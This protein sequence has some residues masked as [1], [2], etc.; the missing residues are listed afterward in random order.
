MPKRVIIDTDPGVDDALALILALRSPELEIEAITTVSGNVPVEQAT[1]NVLRVLNLLDPKPRPPVAKG[2]AGPFKKPLV[3]ATVVHGAD[4]LGDLDRFKNLDGSPRYLE[5]EVPRDLPSA[6]EAILELLGRYPGELTLITLGPLTNLAQALL[7]DR[8]RVKTLREVVIMGGA[9]RAPG[10]ATPAAEF[11]ISIDPHAAQLVFA[12]GLPITLVPLDVTEKV[13]L[14]RDTIETIAQSSNDPLSQF[15][16]DATGKVIEFM[17]RVAEVPA[18]TLHDPLAVG[19][20]IDPSFVKTS[21]L[22]VD[23]ETDGRITEGM[24]VADLRSI[25]DDLKQPPN[26]HGALEVDADRFL[27]FFL[28]RICRRDVTLSVSEGSS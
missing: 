19:V 4:G 16:S 11:N 12:S 1:K 23:V 13:T 28:E 26:L 9:I 6:H 10:N 2:A 17:E 8:E 15:I 24:T 21:P 5:P 18:I 25:R 3:T 27:A 20:V 14:S 7:E 22:H